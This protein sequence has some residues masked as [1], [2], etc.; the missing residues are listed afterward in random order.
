[1][2]EGIHVVRGMCAVGAGLAVGFAAIG[3]GVGQ[4]FAAGSGADAVNSIA[5]DANGNIYGA[6]QIMSTDGDG[7]GNHGSSDIGIIKFSASGSKQWVRMIGGSKSDVVNDIYA[8]A[9]GCVFA[10]TY[11]SKDGDFTL[12]RGAKDAFIGF[13]DTEG[14]VK[15]LRTF[16]GLKNDTFNAIAPTEFGYAAVGITNSENRDLADIGNKGES[17]GFVMSINSAGNVEHVKSLGG[18][19]N[20]NASAICRLD[21]RTYIVT[22]ETYSNDKDFS[23]FTPT[24]CAGIFG[25]FYIY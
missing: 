11:A 19:K 15:W 25:K 22:G 3:P 24:G 12:N 4:G 5:S 14:N 21:S 18:S 17:D 23:T 7:K 16:G 10:G 13:C 20:D 8:G 1:M 9:S 2:I 6:C